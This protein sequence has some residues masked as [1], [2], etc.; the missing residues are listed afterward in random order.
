MPQK[1]IFKLSERSEDTMPLIRQDLHEKSVQL[2]LNP[3]YKYTSY[4]SHRK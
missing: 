2:V 3:I 1:I 4:L